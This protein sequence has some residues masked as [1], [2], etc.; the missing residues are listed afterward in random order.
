MP[1]LTDPIKIFFPPY[2]LYSASAVQCPVLDRANV[3]AGTLNCSHPIAP[4]SY[5]STCEIRC[6]VG[7]EPNVQDQIRCDP[8][9]QWTATIPTCTGNA[10]WQY[11]QE[12]KKKKKSFST[13]FFCL[14]VRSYPVQ[15]VER[16]RLGSQLLSLHFTL[17]A[18]CIRK[19]TLQLWFPLTVNYVSVLIH[20]HTSRSWYAY[21]HKSWC[22]AGQT[23]EF[24][25]IHLHLSGLR[26]TDICL[27][28]RSEKMPPYFVSRYGQRDLCG[29]FGAFLLWLA[30]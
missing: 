7:Y 30:V 21:L 11:L 19:T 6:D 24:H 10:T 2:F 16:N 15:T 25:S 20:A 13:F 14:S 8:A 27:S 5:N 22:P 3:S 23:D 1:A 29:H 4:Y 18:A 9:G 17:I 28:R 26:V 12:F